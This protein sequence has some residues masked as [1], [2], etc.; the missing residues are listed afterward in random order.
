MRIIYKVSV[1]SV[2]L[3]LACIILPGI[4][5][6]HAACSYS[7]QPES[8]S[9]FSYIGNN[10]LPVQNPPSI[11]QIV[12]F[13]LSTNCYPNSNKTWGGLRSMTT[14]NGDIPLP[15]VNDM[16]ASK[17]GRSGDKEKFHGYLEF[18]TTYNDP[19]PNLSTT[20][21]ED[22]VIKSIAKNGGYTFNFK[23]IAADKEERAASTFVKA[24]NCVS[25]GGVN[26]K[27]GGPIKIVF[28]R[29]SDAVPSASLSDYLSQINTIIYKG[30]AAIDPFKAYI[31]KFS[32]YIDLN[33]FD[34]PSLPIDPAT[35]LYDR[36][37]ATTVINSSSCGSDAREYLVMSKVNRL[38]EAYMLGFTSFGNRVSFLTKDSYNYLLGEVVI[39]EMG[40]VFG[41][42]GDEYK[43]GDVGTPG[44]E[45]CASEYVL[46]YGQ[47]RSSKDNHLY[48][49][50]N[51][52]GCNYIKFTDGTP[53][54]RPSTFSIMNSDGYPEH[55]RFNVIS[56][57]YVIAGILGEKI[58]QDTAETHWPA[59]MSMDTIKEGIPAVT[60][61]PVA[62]NLSKVTNSSVANTFKM[63]GSNFTP[64][65][66]SVRLISSATA[67]AQ[68]SSALV[69]T[70]HSFTEKITGFFG[71]VW[72][73]FKN[74]IPYTHG[75][76]ATSPGK[77]YTIAGIP[78]DNTTGTSITFVIPSNIPNG[79]YSVV[80]G[81]YNSDLVTTD[82]KVTITSSGINVSGNPG[83]GSGTYTEGATV[84][85]TA[86]Y[87]CPNN[88]TT[89]RY[90]LTL[91]NTCLMTLVNSGGG[92]TTVVVGG[93][94]G[95][96][97]TGS[98]TVPA[99]LTYV[100]PTI[101]IGTTGYFSL[102]SGSTCVFH[103]Y[104]PT[105]VVTT[106]PVSTTTASTTTKTPL[107]VSTSTTSTSVIPAT[108]VRYT[109]PSS[110]YSL[111]GSM[112]T[113]IRVVC[114]TSLSSVC[115]PQV[116]SA[117]PVYSCPTGYTLSGSVCSKNVVGEGTT[118]ASGTQ[119]SAAVIPTI[120]S[121]T[122]VSV[123]PTV[124]YTCSSGA[125]LSGTSC[126]STDTVGIVANS[127]Y[128]KSASGL[129]SYVY[130]CSSG[131]VLKGQ[132]CYSTAVSITPGVAVYSCAT[133]YTLNAT[134]K[135]CVK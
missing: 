53:I 86:T 131:Y 73:F 95:T 58:S 92:F 130:S 87:K 27:P 114:T 108:L 2:F 16:D 77:A 36:S 84:P 33:K 15:A 59:C 115:N 13:S 31:D 29:S 96:V 123:A 116:L 120:A 132:R 79:I 12:D 71:G 57:G 98:V 121:T 117:T 20:Y 62:S 128:A 94:S 28:M 42:L 82:F 99:I 26:G 40:H 38:T 65:G 104:A 134:T 22:S 1:T 17:V 126:Q 47:Y 19:T 7:Y 70:P 46:K 45:N 103:F 76:V 52:Q 118:T 75:Q 56:C 106:P 78:S 4:K 72:S 101:P 81:S 119:T 10:L 66:N 90:T 21:K 122:Q 67:E 112:C 110:N 74:L 48:G 100:C 64:T 18:N 129:F 68:D 37:S 127:T 124:T 113:Q 23:A 34:A 3:L 25:L 105:P 60:A 39:H 9:A 50:E 24:T 14:V 69:A 44:T 85:A 97:P 135:M 133:G 111:S 32:F 107:P 89:A 88:T 6:A 63:V 54:Y 102:V 80:V 91:A 41:L 83:I 5:S 55:Q 8:L 61:K 11:L 43:R 93:S 49:A 125:T 51:I 30:F 109:C 35:G